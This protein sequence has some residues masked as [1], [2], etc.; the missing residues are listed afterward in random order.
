MKNILFFLTFI[1]FGIFIKSQTISGLVV[2]SQN[3]G[4]AY[5]EISLIKENIKK[6]TISNSN[7]NYEI[8]VPEKG[9]YKLSVVKDGEVIIKKEIGI[10]ENK[11]EN[12]ISEL[13]ESQIQ[14]V[15]IAG[16]KKLIE[17]KI[18]RL[19]FNV[20]NS[21]SASGGD[22]LETMGIIP[23]VKVVNDQIGII[24]KSKVSI[25]VNDRLIQLSE[26]DLLSFLR[27]IKSEDIKNIEVITNPPSKYDSE[28]NS[29]LINIKLKK[30][31][32]NYLSGNLKTSYTQATYSMGNYGAGLNYQKKKITLS[33][34]IDYENGSI[35]PYQE[36]TL[37]YPSYTWFETNKSRS[38]RDNLSGRFSLDYE[39]SKKTTIGIQYLGGINN[40][41]R[42]GNNS[43]E[44]SSKKG[45]DSL[46]ITPSD[47]RLKKYNHAV[48]LHTITKLDSTGKKISFDLDYF[49][50]NSNA[51]NQFSTSSYLPGDYN[52]KT[53]LSANNLSNQDIKIYSSKADIEFPLKWVTLSFGAK[54]SFINNKS[55]VLYFNTTN[56]NPFLDFGKSNTFDYKE[57]TQAIY[58][59]GSKK[60]SKKW[61][62][63]LGFRLENTQTKGY[64]ETLDQA[65]KNNYT[66]LF[67]TLYINY[68]MN[69]NSVFG[70]NYNRRI[71][72]PTY[73]DLNPFR[74]YTT[75]YN[76]GEGNPFL[77]PYFTDNF[78]ISY[79]YKNN[80][81]SAYLSYINNGFDQVTYV[82][83]DNPVQAIIPSNFYKQINLGILESYL[84][85]KW[86]WWESNNQAN[87][88]YTKTMS[89]IPN[90]LTDL[91]G[92][93]ASVSSNNSF[94]LNSAKTLK[95]E[96]GFNYQSPSIAN[97]Y[98]MS[99]FYYFNTGLKLSLLEKKLQIALN[100]MDIFRTY[101]MT[102]TQVVNGIKQENFDYRDTQK[103]RISVNWNFGKTLKIQSRKLSNEE[104]KKR[105]N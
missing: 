58:L 100:I 51:D 91:S 94:T 95:A 82:S 37:Y 80:Y 44:I 68:L 30:A 43:S 84:F 16:K 27:S 15:S 57:N 17:R 61:E 64:S 41:I 8:S 62:T 4:I 75:K 93:S 89:D 98:K 34:N 20:E 24:G 52:A 33:T 72:R 26:N 74:F 63:Q 85:N 104:E 56:G 54:V 28:G 39:I 65:N 49:T 1:F 97:S 81:A 14:G 70:F 40:P 31:K 38:F 23:G 99:S 69:E 45:L 88:F 102:F 87:I 53:F 25:M 46:I 13:K 83:A 73:S 3:Q 48:N 66:K 92:W 32:E 103:I 2:N 79:S 19:V 6:N 5:A 90:T 29:G 105:A 47:L 60:L 71:D 76:Y 10:T 7:G 78:E 22:A 12:L 77:Q 55:D 67:P 96:L 21:I 101:K 18:D 9:T 11:T 59:S 42:K 35:A 50:F 36:Y 86:K